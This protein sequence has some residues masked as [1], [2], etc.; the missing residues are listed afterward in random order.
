M[1]RS[2]VSYTVTVEGPHSDIFICLF[3]LC[4]M[5]FHLN[6]TLVWGWSV[7]PFKFLLFQ[8]QILGLW[9]DF[10]PFPPSLLIKL[11]KWSFRRWWDRKS[12]QNMRP[13]VFIG[14]VSEDR[15][16]WGRR[17]GNDTQEM[18]W[19]RPTDRAVRTL[20]F[21]GTVQSVWQWVW[22]QS[23]PTTQVSRTLNQINETPKQ[24]LEPKTAMKSQC[25]QIHKKNKNQLCGCGSGTFCYLEGW[26]FDRWL[27]QSAC[28]CPRFPLISWLCFFFLLLNWSHFCLWMCSNI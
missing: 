22:R 9:R 20:T 12:F 2:N 5:S 11:V 18:V 4:D 1:I 26:R 21:S 15:K 13:F 25:T 7:G 24:E 8:A 17:G 19:V 27:L 23:N 10:K 28:I 16:V 3:S 6:L 14:K